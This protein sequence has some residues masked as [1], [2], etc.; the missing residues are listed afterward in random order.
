VVVV[1]HVIVHFHVILLERENSRGTL[2]GKSHVPCH[3][4]C[5]HRPSCLVMILQLFVFLQAAAI[6]DHLC[7][8][9]QS[10][11]QK[12]AQ[13]TES[14]E[15]TKKDESMKDKKEED[16]KM[17]MEQQQDE[18]K[19]EENVTEKEE[20]AEVSVTAAACSVFKLRNVGLQGCYCACVG[21]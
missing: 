2:H 1:V 9:T 17:D 18:I 16:E 14:A 6:V 4:A 20:P 11:G 15:K 7:Q 8:T 21:L 12:K 3:M 19:V 10:A 13:P 5:L